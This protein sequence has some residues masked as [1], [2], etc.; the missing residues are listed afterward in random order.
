MS[1]VYPELATP[2]TPDE[3]RAVASAKLR[4]LMNAYD[5]PDTEW[6]V[7]H[8]FDHGTD[9]L[10][11]RDPSAHP[12]LSGTGGDGTAH[13]QLYKVRGK[14]NASAERVF[15]TVAHQRYLAEQK[16]MDPDIVERRVVDRL[17]DTGTFSTMYTRV[18]GK[19][20]VSD[21]EF[22]S[23]RRL[24]RRS[25]AVTERRTYIMLAFS[26]NN[27]G[28]VVH[29]G[30]VRGALYVMGW[31]VQEL[32]EHQCIATRVIKVDPKGWIPAFVVNG[33]KKR[34]A[35]AF[36]TL[37]TLMLDSKIGTLPESKSPSNFN[38]D[39]D[40]DAATAAPRRQERSAKS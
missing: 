30:H 35:G 24:L 21:R 11:L 27:P 12:L 29:P 39:V 9:M 19:R 23:V 16:Q 38:D 32:S 26:Y 5:L 20:F 6:N 22:W 25:D 13:I 10:T 15:T 31:V 17:N 34:T 33:Y 14:V 3:F 40:D 1:A 4:Q 7:V 37:R 36:S 2:T 8:D 28:A 18:R